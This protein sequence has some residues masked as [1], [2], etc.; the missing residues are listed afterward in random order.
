MLLDLVLVRA[1]PK[2]FM[3]IRKN[4]ETATNIA[5]S[6]QKMKLFF[7]EIAGPAPLLK[8]RDSRSSG[9]TGG[10]VKLQAVSFSGDTEDGIF[11]VRRGMGQQGVVVKVYYCGW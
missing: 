2:K 11:Q 7:S 9:Y 5:P 6:E 8:R 10:R 4:K 1:K 3:G